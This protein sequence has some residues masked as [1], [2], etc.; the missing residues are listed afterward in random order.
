MYIDYHVGE[1]RCLTFEKTFQGTVVYT[2]E[3]P[4]QR[5][6]IVGDIKDPELKR[7]GTFWGSACSTAG[8]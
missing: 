3:G 1:S 4:E 2:S 8:L 7:G 5:I 6:W